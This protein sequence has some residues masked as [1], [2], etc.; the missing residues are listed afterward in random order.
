MERVDCAVI[1]AGVVGLAIARAL[2]LAGREVIILERAGA[3]GTETSSRNSEVIH[4]G[5]YYPTGSLRARFC[6]AGKQALYRYCDEHGVAYKRLGKL[7]VATS[8]GEIAILEKYQQQALQ[9]GVTDLAWL[10]PEAVRELEPAVRCVR[11]LHSPSTG[12]VDS[13]GLMLALLGDAQAHGASLA[14][15]SPV[16][17]GAATGDGLTIHVG[18]AEPLSLR[19]NLLINAAGLYAQDVA[20]TINGVPPQSIPPSRYA[21]GHYFVL[22]GKPPF[23][24]LI[25]PVAVHGSLGLHVA[26]DLAGQVRFGPDIH[27]I[28]RVDYTFDAGRA[29]LFYE[30]VRRYYPELRDGALQPGYTGIRP[31]LFGPNEAPKDFDIQDESRH[32]VAGLVNLYGIDSPGLTS[33]LAIGD[34]VARMV[35]RAADK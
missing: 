15:R 24:R 19:C 5:I 7:V 12:I 9:N 13:H 25:Y 10:T 35:A 4:A 31:K 27:W 11:A 17:S 8:P 33:A 1:G 22:S 21:I 6:V 20:R 18:G 23:T 14:L 26:L 3:I 30:S 29:P 16:Q 28:D 34:Y 2:A 32:G